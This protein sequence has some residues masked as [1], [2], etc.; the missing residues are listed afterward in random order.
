MTGPGVQAKLSMT[1]WVISSLRSDAV[2]SW[3]RLEVT[4]TSPAKQDKL[5]LCA[6]HL[7]NDI[8][9]SVLIF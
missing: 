6:Q 4:A 5:D 8:L 1:D 3:S 9:S 7:G 2:R